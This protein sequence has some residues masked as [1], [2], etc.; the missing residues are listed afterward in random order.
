MS[1]VNGTDEFE[2]TK[3]KYQATNGKGMGQIGKQ[4]IDIMLQTMTQENIQTCTEISQIF[5]ADFCIKIREL[6]GLRSIWLS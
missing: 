4:I 3:S 1:K 5:D 6:A 2:L